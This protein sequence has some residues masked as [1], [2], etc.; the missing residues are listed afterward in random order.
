MFGFVTK[1]VIT[2]VTFFC[3]P[4]L[5]EIEVFSRQSHNLLISLTINS[6]DFTYNIIQTHDRNSRFLIPKYLSLSCILICTCSHNKYYLVLD[7]LFKPQE[8]LETSASVQSPAAVAHPAPVQ[9]AAAP[10]T[11]YYQQPQ[12]QYNHQT[13]TQTQYYH[14]PQPLPPVNLP[15]FQYHRYPAQPVQ[16]THRIQSRIDLFRS[17]VDSLQSR[18]AQGMTNMRS[19]MRNMINQIVDYY[20]GFLSRLDQKAKSR[21]GNSEDFAPLIFTLSSLVIGAVLSM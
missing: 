15:Q 3:F 17:R 13:P 10:Q 5:K 18:M 8:T 20:R 14:Q 21:S 12:T 9:V 2:C 4:S 19:S 16:L 1:L 7:F 6:L 11:Q